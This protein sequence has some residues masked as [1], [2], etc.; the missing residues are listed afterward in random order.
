MRSSFFEYNVAITGLFTARGA[1]EVA[2]HNIS[3][4]ETPGYSRQYAEIRASHPMALNNG[5]GMVG[6]GSEIYGIGQ[7]RSFYLDL[8][9]WG[10]NPVYGEYAVKNS[11]LKLIETV[12]SVT[13]EDKATEYHINGA[14]NKFFNT[15]QDLSTT[16]GDKVYRTSVLQA[17]QTL[18][19]F[20]NNTAQSLKK[21]Q[22]EVND[23]VKIITNTISSLGQQI[24][25][26]NEQIFKY[27]MDG[28]YANDLRDAR[29]L[30][31]D[32]LSGYVN[33]EV[34][35]VEMNQDYALGKYPGPEYRG[36]SQKQFSVFIN[37]EE[38]VKHLDYSPM[39]VR[40]RETGKQTNPYDAPGLYDIYFADTN[41][42]LDIY[43]PT[44]QGE[45]K[46]LIDVRDGNNGF[47][48]TGT[49]TNASASATNKLVLNGLSRLDYSPSGGKVTLINPVTGRSSDHYYTAFNPTTF[50]FTIDPKT[51]L[52]NDVNTVAYQVN[53]G[54]TS[55][56]KGIPHYIN[57]LNELV[58]TFSWAMNEG[59]G[60]IK[61]H[62]D[63]YDAY[64]GQAQNLFF[65][66]DPAQT[67][68][69]GFNTALDYA[70][71]N[72]FNFQVNSELLRDPYL[73]AMSDSN[74]PE[75]SNNKIVLDLIQI[76][77][78]KSLFKEGK[79]E[80]FIIGISGE[81]GIDRDQAK[82]FT[83]NYY[84]IVKTVDNQRKSVSGVDRNEEGVDIVKFQQLFVA[85]SKMVNVIDTIYD[86]LIN[87]LGNF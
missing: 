7:Y 21:Q 71:L 13:F 42:K 29:A 60:G 44:L 22:K 79:L 54:Q 20:I 84:E 78:Y 85:A 65:T 26:L 81:L 39:E 76:R 3:N 58:R 36:L 1:L 66:Y 27:E 32:E 17:G 86:T 15:L 38:F 62:K 47:Y 30:L 37:G 80:D 8:K 31:V 6:T 23:E 75:E 68:Y 49:A 70:K 64:Q 41:R 67:G 55:D 10:E 18:A 35:E 57:K 33:V 51:P 34:R 77:T 82:S 16:A 73:L 72:A 63:G 48:G 2:N 25:N 12:F 19:K 87:R 5:K 14:M 40:A 43:S 11:Q 53:V 83:V 56:Y 46:G 24:R 45:L 74:V 4:S 69:A 59:V 50:E 61:G 52:P 28:S 9:Y